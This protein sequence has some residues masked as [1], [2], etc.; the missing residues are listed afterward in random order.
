MQKLYKKLIIKKIKNRYFIFIEYQWTMS[1]LVF[2]LKKKLHVSLIYN[3][4]HSN[5]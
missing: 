5:C 1:N 3:Y 2:F 4:L